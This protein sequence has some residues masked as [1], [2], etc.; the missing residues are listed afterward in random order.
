MFRKVD[1]YTIKT[2][3]K[4]SLDIESEDSRE[5]SVSFKN[6]LTIVNK[7]AN[8]EKLIDV[9]DINAYVRAQ[10]VIVSGSRPA[11]LQY[12]KCGMRVGD[13]ICPR[14]EL[15]PDMMNEWNQFIKNNFS[16]H[17]QSALDEQQEFVWKVHHWFL[18]IHP[19]EDGNGRTARL[20]LNQLRLAIGLPWYVVK[21]SEA[22][23]Y[24]RAIEI[25]EEI[26]FPQIM[27]KYY[28]KEEKQP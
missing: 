22:Y 17:T 27:E 4:N 19:F 15:V 9:K 12:R 2:F 21:F 10:G 3:I 11:P 14:P 23:K 18:C 13:S 25:W 28:P 24:Y 16:Y 1:E 6:N 20:F 26:S 7:I 8:G 5:T